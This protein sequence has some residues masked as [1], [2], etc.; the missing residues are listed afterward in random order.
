MTCLFMTQMNGSGAPY[1]VG[2]PR[3]S[4]R[5]LDFPFQ[6]CEFGYLTFEESVTSLNA[7]LVGTDTRRGGAL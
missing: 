7:I 2:I 5:T 6:H 1:V 4:Q 3:R